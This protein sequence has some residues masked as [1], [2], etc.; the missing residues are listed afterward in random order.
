MMDTHIPKG[1]P[2]R[3][4]KRDSCPRGWNQHGVEGSADR[5][6]KLA[7][8]TAVAKGHED[9]SVRLREPTADKKQLPSRRDKK[10][11]REA[12][13]TSGALCRFRL[14]CVVSNFV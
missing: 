1:F 12:H 9:Q 11:P 14:E 4:R 10:Y 7:W 8:E 13:R 5:L 2:L 6:I 3:F